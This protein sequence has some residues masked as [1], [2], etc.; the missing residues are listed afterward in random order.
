V[1]FNENGEPCWYA[2]ATHCR[3]NKAQLPRDWDKDFVEDMPGKIVSYGRPASN[4]AKQLL[5]IFVMLGEV[6]DPKLVQAFV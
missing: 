1:F 5:R 6:V 3:D 4:Q 2:I